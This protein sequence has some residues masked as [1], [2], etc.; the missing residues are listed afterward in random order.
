MNIVLNPALEQQLKEVAR[1]TQKTEQQLVTEALER[2]LPEL[3]PSKNC[4]DLALELGVMVVGEDL[5][6]DLSTNP[7]YLEGLGT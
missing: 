2:H 3:R 5:P 6:P 7:D 4:Y 1:L